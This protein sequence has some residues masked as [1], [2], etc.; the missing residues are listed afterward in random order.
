VSS[1]LNTVTGL[2]IFD[3]DIIAGVTQYIDD[4]HQMKDNVCVLDNEYRYHQR[5]YGDKLVIR[6]IDTFQAGDNLIL[7]MP[8]YYGDIHVDSDKILAVTQ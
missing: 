8:L 2:E 3:R 6:T 1:K 7:S 4:I 5:L